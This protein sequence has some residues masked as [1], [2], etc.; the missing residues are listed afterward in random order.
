MDNMGKLFV[1]VFA[2]TP[3]TKTNPAETCTRTRAP[4]RNINPVT[5]QISGSD[6]TFTATLRKYP[7]CNI[8][9]ILTDSFHLS[10]LYRDTR[11]FD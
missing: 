3:A 8:C 4:A 10:N 6:Q 7:F 1:T 2:F 11:I 9:Y 5:W